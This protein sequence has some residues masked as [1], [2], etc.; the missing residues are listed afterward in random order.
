MSQNAMIK[1]VY[2]SAIHKVS[3]AASLFLN[4]LPYLA[5]NSV[6]DLFG[7]LGISKIFHVFLTR[8][9]LHLFYEPEHCWKFF[10]LFFLAIYFQ[11]ILQIFIEMIPFSGLFVCLSFFT[12]FFFNCRELILLW[13][14]KVQWEVARSNHRKKFPWD[15][16]SAHIFFTQSRSSCKEECKAD[17]FSFLLPHPNE[18]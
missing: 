4:I 17:F 9:V 3:I 6:C 15:V 7:T 1:N 11:L 5:A 12:A 18:R 13:Y 8:T 2:N 10:L 16:N 14:I